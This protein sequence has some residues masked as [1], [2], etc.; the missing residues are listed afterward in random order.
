[1]SATGKFQVVPPLS[2]EEFTA[3]KADIAQRGVLVPIEYDEDGNVLDGHHRVLACEELGV[4]TWARIIRSDLGS[5]HEKREHARALNLARRHLSSEA[6][7]L[8]IAGQLRN[9]PERPDRRIAAALVLLHPCAAHPVRCKSWH[10]KA[11]TGRIGAAGSGL[12]R[13]AI[14]R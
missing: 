12:Q 14:H 3:L 8:V 4:T 7:R 6:K 11:A 1:M 5:D 13:A 9:T 10:G 2:E